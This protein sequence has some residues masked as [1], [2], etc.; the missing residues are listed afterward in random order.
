[1]GKAKRGD[2]GGQVL[3]G[4]RLHQFGKEWGGRARGAMLAASGKRRDGGGRGTEEGGC[5]VG[6]ACKRYKEERWRGC[7]LGWLCWAAG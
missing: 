4:W 3:A 6:S 7:L 2:S 1:M 5:Q